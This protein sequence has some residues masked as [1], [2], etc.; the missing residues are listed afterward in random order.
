MNKNIKS[1]LLLPA[2]ILSS[3]INCFN[4]KHRDKAQVLSDK[5]NNCKEIKTR[6]CNSETSLYEDY[7][8][9]KK[10]EKIKKNA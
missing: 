1:F 6:F 4:Q 3:S 7:K 9:V 8:N 10:I 5:N 2:L